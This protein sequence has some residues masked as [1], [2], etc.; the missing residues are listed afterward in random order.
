MENTR[1]G[2]TEPVAQTY[3]STMILY[4]AKSS[5]Q[6]VCL[7]AAQ[8]LHELLFFKALQQQ[9]HDTAELRV[10]RSANFPANSEISVQHHA[11]CYV[12]CIFKAHF[13]AIVLYYF[14][15]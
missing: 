4:T 13:S 7:F 10:N 1:E 12:C 14:M 9:H 3:K 6:D 8:C 2:D 11:V 15:F 5:R